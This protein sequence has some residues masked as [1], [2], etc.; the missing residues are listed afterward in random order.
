MHILQIIWQ[1]VLYLKIKTT[2]RFNLHTVQRNSIREYNSMRINATAIISI[3]FYQLKFTCF[4]MRFSV[5][6]S[7][8][9]P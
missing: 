7:Y 3:N 2:I 6:T 9:E 1:C 4:K 8:V 5:H